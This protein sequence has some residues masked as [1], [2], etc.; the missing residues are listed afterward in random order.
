MTSHHFL[1][2]LLLAVSLATS[3]CGFPA[4]PIVEEA[5][6]LRIILVPAPQGSLDPASGMG[7]D[8]L[9][10][11]AGV[12][13]VYLRSISGGGHVLATAERVSPSAVAEILQRLA[14]DPAIAQ[15]EEDRRASHQ[16]P[17]VTP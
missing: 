6:V 14:A 8:Q 10:R 1:V 17:R 9:S 5:R 12:P 15:V 7:L 4:K 11:V 2:G 13:L 3:A 16:S